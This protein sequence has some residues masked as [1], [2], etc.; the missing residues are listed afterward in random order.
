MKDAAKALAVPA[1]RHPDAVAADARSLGRAVLG[2]ALG[3]TAFGLVMVYSWTAVKL[4]HARTG[5]DPDRVLLKQ[6][7]WT[8]IACAAAWIASRISLD[9]LR[10]KAPLVLGILLALP[11]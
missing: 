4:S 6:A 7:A 9:W 1:L 3:L 10:A 8:A 11:G 2:I 5:L